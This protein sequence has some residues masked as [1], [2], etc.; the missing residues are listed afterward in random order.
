MYNI[1]YYRIFEGLNPTKWIF[2]VICVTLKKLF[3]NQHIFYKYVFYFK[4][5]NYL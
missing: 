3:E 4:V 1:Q 5:L 2:D